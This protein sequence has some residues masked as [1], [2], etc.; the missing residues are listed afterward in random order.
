M[1]LKEIEKIIDK[2]D[3]YLI[4]NET[5]EMVYL[6]GTFG[7]KRAIKNRITSD[8]KEG[9][10]CFLYKFNE[11]T[12]DMTTLAKV[13]HID[14]EKKIV[15]KTLDEMTEEELDR[16][17]TE[18]CNKISCRECPLW[19]DKT[20]YGC[21]AASFHQWRE[22]YFKWKDKEIEFEVEE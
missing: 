21:C 16:I 15:R 14:K 2:A 12:G 10:T 5:E 11:E 17:S 4:K 9:Y 3:I 22:N 20:Y 19:A 6:L 1:T 8:V 13:D 18:F 7:I